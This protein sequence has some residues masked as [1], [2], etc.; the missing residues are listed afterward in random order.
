[1]GNNEARVINIADRKKPLLAIVLPIVGF[2][3][4]R[5]FK[6]EGCNPEIDPMFRNIRQSLRFVPLV[7]QSENTPKLGIEELVIF[8]LGLFSKTGLRSWV[9]YQNAKYVYTKSVH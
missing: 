5:P 7:F 2:Q 3:D 6:D 9:A 1:M 4:D 8:S